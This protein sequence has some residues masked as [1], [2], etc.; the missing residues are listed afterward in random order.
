MWVI[1]LT[2]GIG[3]G[4]STVADLFARLG[5]P[6]ID[7][8]LIARQ[9]TEPGSEALAEIHV[10][11]PDTVPDPAGRLDR[12]RLR[13]LVFSDVVARQKL[14]AILHPRIGLEVRNS[15]AR[16]Q[17]PYAMVVIPLLVETGGYHDVLN[18]V[19]VVDC[20]EAQQIERVMT[21]NGL[22][23]EAVGRIMAIQAS[24]ADRLAAADDVILNAGTPEALQV[25]VAD[26]HQ[27]YLN[28]AKTAPP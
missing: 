1:G 28:F 7:T 8:D 17:A 26:L 13:D 21:R 15:L 24:R 18:R 20:P 16:V 23:H 4:K 10:A 2:G 22:S 6:I 25:T 9:L 12:A 27:R 5:V 19:L 14:E 11:F 3:S